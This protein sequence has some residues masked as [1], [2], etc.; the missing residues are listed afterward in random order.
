MRRPLAALAVLAAVG[1]GRRSRAWPAAPPRRR[2]RRAA[3][4]LFPRSFTLNQRVDRLP[5][6]ADS[7][8]IVASI[9]PTTR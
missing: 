1:R 9:G 7:D 5:V 3:C 8:R 4:P 2:R 6:A